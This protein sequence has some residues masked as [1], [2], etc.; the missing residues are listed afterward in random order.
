LQARTCETYVA[1]V[2]SYTKR[3]D[4]QNLVSGAQLFLASQLAL[5]MPV[6]KALICKSAPALERPY[7][8]N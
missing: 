8:V 6:K 2:S 3:K 1:E 4:L 5:Q 7:K